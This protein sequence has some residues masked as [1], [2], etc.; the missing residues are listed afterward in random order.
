MFQKV[1][2]LHYQVIAHICEQKEHLD[3]WTKSR[4]A[5]LNPLCSEPK[6]RHFLGLRQC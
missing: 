4:A 3:Y 2:Q 5:R 1:N 6:A